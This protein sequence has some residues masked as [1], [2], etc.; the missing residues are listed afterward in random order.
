MPCRQSPLPSAMPW[1][2]HPA[3]RRNAGEAYGAAAVATG[4]ASDADGT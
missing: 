3:W 1:P 4:V 2:I